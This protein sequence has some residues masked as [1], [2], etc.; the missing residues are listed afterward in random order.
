MSEEY[1]NEMNKISNKVIEEMSKKGLTLRQTRETL[2]EIN[3]RTKKMENEIKNIKNI[4]DKH[5]KQQHGF[6]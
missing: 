5:C 4:L 6:L 2:D 3:E 1:Q